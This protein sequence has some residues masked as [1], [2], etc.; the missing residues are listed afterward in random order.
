MRAREGE[1]RRVNTNSSVM[2]DGGG[3]EKVDEE[4]EENG[5]G[6]KASQYGVVKKTFSAI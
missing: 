4:A 5:G 2:R 3:G 6:E 1:S